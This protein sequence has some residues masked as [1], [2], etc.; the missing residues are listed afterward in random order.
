[1]SLEQR[2]NMENLHQRH[3]VTRGVEDG[4]KEFHLCW[5][6][7]CLLRVKFC[8]HCVYSSSGDFGWV[9]SKPNNFVCC[10]LAEF[11]FGSSVFWLVGGKARGGSRKIKLGGYTLVCDGGTGGTPN[12]RKSLISKKCHHQFNECRA[13][14]LVSFNRPAKKRINGILARSGEAKLKSGDYRLPCSNVESPL[15]K[16]LYQDW[17]K[18][19]YQCIMNWSST[20]NNYN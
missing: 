15:G 11:L 8:D 19:E 3:H 6:M 17:T 2:M 13:P 9:F 16:V 4:G 5:P 18:F 7:F 10:V 12:S 14:H 20:T 1:M